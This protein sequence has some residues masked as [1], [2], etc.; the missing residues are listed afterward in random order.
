MRISRLRRFLADA[1]AITLAAGAIASAGGQA[2]DSARAL[3]EEAARAAGARDFRTAAGKYEDFL[4][5][6]AEHAEAP[7]AR[8]G[9]ALALLRLPERDFA[10]IATLL[11]TAAAAKNFP[12]RA[13]AS[14]WCGVALREWARRGSG[15]LDL[16]ALLRRAAAQFGEAARLWAESAGPPGDGPGELP[17]PLESALLA[18]A[19][20]AEALLAL[21]LPREAVAV[22]EPL[23]RA[24]WTARSRHRP[25]LDYLLGCAWYAA[26]E[27][28]AAGRALVRL[29]PFSQP[30]LGPHA[31][32][33]LARI[34]HEAGEAA[35][36]ADH[37]E[38]VP[39]LYD[40]HLQAARREL[41]DNA[42]PLRDHPLEHE[43][44][45]A[46]VKGPAPAWV[47]D[48]LFWG[49]ILLYEQKKFH[50]AQIRFE[51]LPQR[52]PAHPRGDEARLLVGACQVQQGRYPE[53]EKTLQPLLPHPQLG[54]RAHLWAA[55]AVAR[56]P[57]AAPAALARAA[58]L[59]G[60]AREVLSKNPGTSGEATEASLELADLHLR[61]GRPE[62]AASLYRDLADGPWGEE[63][64]A[65]L[66]AA[67]Q[68]AGRPREAEEA[69]RRFEKEHPFSPLMAETMFHHAECAFA[70]AQAAGDS[71]EHR[72]LYD[73]AVR[74][75]ERVVARYPDLPQ[76]NLC[77]FRLAT[78]LYAV[79]RYA[80]AAAALVSIPEPERGGPLAASSHVLGDA[81]LRSGPSPDEARDAVAASRRLQQLQLAIQALQAFAGSAPAEAPELPD[82]LMKLGFAQQQVARLLGADP[83]ARAQAAQAAVQTYEQ[84][85]SRFPSHPLR[86]V[87]EYERANAI[88]L[89][90]N[91]PTALGKF[92]RF[93]QEPLS[94]APIAPVALLRE[95]QLLRSLQRGT[96][97]AAVMAE[98]RQ[99]YE[100]ELKKDPARAGWVPLLRFHHA[101]AL[102]AA[103]QGAEAAKV[104]QALLQDAP[105]GPWS[106]PARTL[107]Q[108]KKP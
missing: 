74:R 58:A 61:M 7:R 75:Y 69:F 28:V 31:R 51:R 71:P 101:L 44:L 55:R 13:S 70:A 105:D 78:A 102:R 42:A 16:P 25:H 76:A 63:A 40:Q 6:H 98:C 14:Y 104:L 89:G 106:G 17:P 85:R 10:K 52:N 66:V 77:R 41:Q 49:G 93:H 96:E 20:Q 97:A 12:E 34:H 24:P 94:K 21:S 43:R 80:Q 45:E 86:A 103:G 1:A 62:E 15:P 32:Y 65:R 33:L 107:L 2:G 59:Y 54:G 57:D 23:L 99:K 29:A 81:L 72:P 68:R 4:R 26:G 46:A 47:E 38:A 64:Q 95:A 73:E 91:L 27:P 8:Y 92:P 30:F 84:V 35:E 11:E 53:A 82:V 90:G 67:L 50:E 56:P 88:A 87:A 60:R 9:C 37:Y 5:S 36:A 100:E 22:L 83:Q 3:L 18:R 79:G 39:A 48:A 108:E 19:G